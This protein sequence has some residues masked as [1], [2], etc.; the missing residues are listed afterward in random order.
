MRPA[1]LVRTLSFSLLLVLTAVFPVHSQ[2]PVDPG[3]LPGRTS[4]YVYWHGTPSGE[5]RKNNSLY[6]LW[7]DPD[8]AAA[9]AAWVDSF[10]SEAQSQK[11]ADKPKLSREELAQYVT[12]LDNAFVAGMLRE[13]EDRA[14]KRA[15]A[16][17]AAKDMP[18]WDGT[19]FIYDRTGKEELLSKAVLRMR[20]GSTDIPKLT[21]L[22]VAGV[23]ALKIERKA[24]TTYW[25]EFGKN[26]VAA[27][28][29]SV[30]E[31][32]LQVVNGKPGEGALAHLPAYLEAKPLLTGGVLEFF[33]AVPNLKELALDSRSPAPPSSK[34]FVDAIKLDSLHSIAGHLVLDG[35]KTHLEA[36]V[37]GD[38]ASGSLF[39]IWSDGTANPASLAYVS[40]DTI[41]Y[42]ESQFNLLGVYQTLKRAFQ[43]G[44]NNTAQMV[45]IVESAAQTRLGMPLEDALAIPTGEVAWLQTSPTLEESQK[46]YLFGVANK[47]SALKLTRT[48]LG[49]R[50]SSEK[51]EGDVTYL[52]ISL[53]GG[54]SSKGVAQW[55]FYHVAVTPSLMMG[56]ARTE[57]LRKYASQPPAPDA[58][59]AKTMLTV[60]AKYPPKL[61]GFS[62]ID[63][64][65][66]DWPGLQAKWIA[67]AQKSAQKAK[68][69]DEAKTDK[70]LADWLAG[71]NPEV[72]PRHLHTMAGASWKDAKGVHFDEWL[73]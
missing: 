58:A 7:D 53:Q 66:V 44:P 73:D 2:T 34:M 61:N 17:T 10:L 8:F 69:N 67:E 70:K 24:S 72:F 11:P 57:T 12:L 52:K 46:V 23:A 56:S 33:L 37:L 59:L 54:Q 60:R 47:A 15:A 9:R 65:K 14:A 38:T 43:Q 5:I 63:F 48:L 49:D 32:I 1:R 42:S 18:A 27:N 39:D 22:T 51:N 16:G 71:V 13:P 3:Q 35:T 36:A 68:S 26:A 62:Y 4:F 50:I 41:Y 31:Q 25:A 28:D 6:A 21:N 19:F 55:N 29:A 20:S 30:F 40:P 45:T 64:Q